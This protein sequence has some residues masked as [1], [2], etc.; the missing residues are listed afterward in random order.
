MLARC[1]GTVRFNGY[2]A[3]SHARYPLDAPLDELALGPCLRGRM[4]KRLDIVM[5]SEDSGRRDGRRN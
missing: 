4:T 1:V 2:R 3:V 5:L